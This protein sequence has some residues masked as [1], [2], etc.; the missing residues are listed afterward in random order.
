MSATS[1]IMEDVSRFVQIIMEVLLVL[2]V[3]GT[4]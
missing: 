3:M 2:V 1:T 4:V